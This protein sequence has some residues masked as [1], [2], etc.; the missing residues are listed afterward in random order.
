[1]K[2]LI[3]PPSNQGYVRVRVSTPDGQTSETVVPSAEVE[4]LVRRIKKD[5][6]RLLGPLADTAIISTEEVT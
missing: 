3:K 1:M 2:T 4:L 6:E 5:A